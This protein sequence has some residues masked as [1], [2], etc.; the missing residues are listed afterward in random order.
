MQVNNGAIYIKYRFLFFIDKNY[1]IPEQY[2]HL[3]RISTEKFS[4]VHRHLY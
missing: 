4:E 2:L 3:K 1:K